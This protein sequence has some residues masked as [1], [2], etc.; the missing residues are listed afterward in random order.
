MSSPDVIAA[1]K[2]ALAA[3]RDKIA[4]EPPPQH[5]A[6]AHEALAKHDRGEHIAPAVLDAARLALRV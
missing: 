3:L 1:H 4:K 2:A 6:W 5:L